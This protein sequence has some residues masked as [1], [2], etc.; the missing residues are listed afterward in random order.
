MS[1]HAL[2]LHS[3]LFACDLAFTLICNCAVDPVEVEGHNMAV[4]YFLVFFSLKFNLAGVENLFWQAQAQGFLN[5]FNPS[6]VS[7]LPIPNL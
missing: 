5:F 3:S 6:P 1:Y 4:E 2:P 7:D